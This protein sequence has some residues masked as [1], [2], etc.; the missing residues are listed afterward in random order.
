MSLDLAKLLLVPSVKLVGS[1][2]NINIPILTQVF[3]KPESSCVLLNEFTAEISSPVISNDVIIIR[4]PYCNSDINPLV[5]LSSGYA[6]LVENGK[7]IIIEEKLDD[8]SET[9]FSNRSKKLAERCGFEL[10]DQFSIAVPTTITI[11]QKKKKLRWRVSSINSQN[12]PELLELFHE[13]FGQKI[14]TELWNW[15]YADE[16]GI[17]VI[18]WHGKQIVAHFGG[19]IRPTLFFGTHILAAPGGDV[20]VKPSERG[21]FT[22]KGPFFLAAASYSETYIGQ[23][24]KHLIGFG[25]PNERH[26]RLGEN[27]GIY[28]LVD[29]MVEINWIPEPRS[30]YSRF[31]LV[32]LQ[33]ISQQIQ[34]TNKLWEQMSRDLTKY[35][36]GI[37]DWSYIKY[38]YLNHP[39]N[40]Y[41][42][43]FIRDII[44]RRII[45][46]VVLHAVEDTY[47]LMDIIGPLKYLPII[48]TEAKYYTEHKGMVKIFCLINESI[49]PMFVKTGGITH[50]LDMNI[51]TD[52]WSPGP[53]ADKIKGKWWLMPGDMDFH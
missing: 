20:M 45:G 34:L 53:L 40:Q 17:G 7:L 19:S 30:R 48:I 46:I 2:E 35:I 14:S 41:E 25:F 43:F 31:T 29:K 22:K 44:F 15:K 5:L 16:K 3:N 49:V 9:F 38:R 32:P 28:A 33:E 42:V 27:M 23:G 37:R 8:N 26:L 39:E 50:S 13:S 52:V 21:A 11:L 1:Y 4:N 47:E 12:I 6:Q 24:A 18:V 10:L 51:P 36:V